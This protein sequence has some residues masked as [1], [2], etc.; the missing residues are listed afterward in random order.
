MALNKVLIVGSAPDALK[1]ADW[2]TSCF[3]HTIVINNDWKA[4]P[5][6]SCLIYPE[7]F[8][9]DRRPGNE[10]SYGKHIVTAEEFVPVQNEFGGFV[11]A[12]GTMS[13]DSVMLG[14]IT[15]LQILT[16]D[17]WTDAM[18]DLMDIVSVNAWIFFI[19]VAVL[20]GFFLVNLFLAVIFDEFM[21]SQ[22]RAAA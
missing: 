5:S 22:A 10:D 7:D 6:W 1:T 16:F 21:K 4:C 11:Y 12:G 18:Y 3:S 2:D 8:P 9:V 19:L 13:F 15:L 17:T 14:Q 20:G